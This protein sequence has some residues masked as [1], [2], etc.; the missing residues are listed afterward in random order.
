MYFQKVI[1]ITLNLHDISTNF[2]VPAGR[3]A[4]SLRL[5]LRRARRAKVIPAASRAPSPGKSTLALPSMT[6]GGTNELPFSPSHLINAS[7]FTSPSVAGPSN[8]SGIGL[9]PATLLQQQHAGIVNA[10][11]ESGTDMFEF[12]Q[13]FAEETMERAGL[14]HGDQ[15]P[16]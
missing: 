12:D 14:G 1:A 15:L 5:I 9:S 8:P 4:R 7:Y 13:L 2:I 3:Y 10:S 16:L 11:P 6:P